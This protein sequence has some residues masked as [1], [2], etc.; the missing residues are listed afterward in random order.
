MIYQT[1]K[2]WEIIFVANL[3]STFLIFAMFVYNT[4]F[5]DTH[6]YLLINTGYLNFF[7]IGIVSLIVSSFA[8]NLLNIKDTKRKL[9]IPK[10]IYS[11]LLFDV[12]LLIQ[13]VALK[14]ILITIF[15][16]DVT[17]LDF[18]L[19]LSSLLNTL[20]FVL[21][22]FTSDWRVVFRRD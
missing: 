7:V 8:I 15:P 13:T 9:I 3:V 22:V 2:I 17:I 10:I 14:Y 4:L 18:I 20:L 11:L 12:T 16:S 6:N 1:S 21:L 5:L 19:L